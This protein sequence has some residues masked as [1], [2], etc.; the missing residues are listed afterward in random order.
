MKSWMRYEQAFVW[1]ATI[2]VVLMVLGTTA[3]VVDFSNQR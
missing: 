3:F 1:V 2:V